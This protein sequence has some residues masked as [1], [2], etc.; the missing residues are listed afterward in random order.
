MNITYLRQGRVKRATGTKID[1][2]HGHLKIKPARADWAAIWVSPEEVAAGSEKP[3]PRPRKPSDKPK[4]EKR[5]R[6]P[7]PEPVPRW[8]QLVDQARAANADSRLFP[9]ITMNFVMELA[10]E[11]ERAQTMFRQ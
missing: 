1:E 8:K 4:S 7:K 11:L 5:P 9:G 2:S 10:D 6:A 3:A